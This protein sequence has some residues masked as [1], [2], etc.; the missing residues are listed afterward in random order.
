MQKCLQ[1]PNLYPPIL[2]ILMA[3]APNLMF[4]RG[5]LLYGMLQFAQGLRQSVCLLPIYW[6]FKS[7]IQHFEHTSWFFAVLPT[8]N[9]APETYAC[10]SQH[11]SCAQIQKVSC[12]KFPVTILNSSKFRALHAWF[13]K[14]AG[15][16]DIFQVWDMHVTCMDWCLNFMHVSCMFHAWKICIF[17]AWNL[18]IPGVFQAWYRRIPCVVQA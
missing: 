10:M 15:V 1:L 16:W 8:Q 2:F 7:S 11:I 9:G 4:T 13:L 6:L 3:G 14:H 17:H 12:M 18:H 5:F